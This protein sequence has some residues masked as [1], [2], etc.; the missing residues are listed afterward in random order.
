MYY[1]NFTLL[2]YLLFYLF[3]IYFAD[4]DPSY[5]VLIG[6]NQ[7]TEFGEICGDDLE[8]PKNQ[9]NGGI[10]TAVIII[11]VVVV[12]VVVV[13]TIV[14]IR[15]GLPHLKLRMQVNNETKMQ[16]IRSESAI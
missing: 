14:F 12:S 1:F 7:Q 9:K 8:Q 13:G 5:T 6:A 4:I 2:L 10:S 16:K 15:Y 3:F 11:I